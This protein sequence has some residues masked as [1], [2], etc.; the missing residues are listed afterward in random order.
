MWHGAALAR[1]C[2]RCGMEKRLHGVVT[3][4]LWSS[5]CP[6]LSPL[7]HGEAFARG[8]HRCGMEQRL[9]GAVTDVAWR[10]A[11]TPRDTASMLA[12]PRLSL[13]YNCNTFTRT[14]GS[15]FGIAVSLSSPFSNMTPSLRAPDRGRASLG[16]PGT[17]SGKRP[18]ISE[19][20]RDFSGR[21]RGIRSARPPSPGGGRRSG[22][23]LSKTVVLGE[24]GESL[25]QSKRVSRTRKWRLI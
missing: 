7:W 5:T 13:V 19:N 18:E 25:D 12:Q 23:K 9:H 4:V 21:R 16:P 17:V 20:P 14:S 1:G 8:C 6:R 24:G 11:C 15:H 2:L 22:P 3:D 10:S